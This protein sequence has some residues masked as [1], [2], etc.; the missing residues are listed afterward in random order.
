MLYS[1]IVSKIKYI[2]NTF[3]NNKNKGRT[4]VALTKVIFTRLVYSTFYSI[5]NV[6]SF[7]V[8]N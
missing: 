8:S 1:E 7:I 3:S 4:D 5:K 2:Y 6:L